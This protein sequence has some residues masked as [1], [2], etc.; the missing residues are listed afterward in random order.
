MALAAARAQVVLPLARAAAS[1]K[2]SRGWR[3]FGYACLD[4]LTRERYGRCGRWLVEVARLNGCFERLPGLAAAVCGEDGGHPLHVS[5]ALAIGDI[6]TPRSLA[7]WIAL[8]RGNTLARLRHEIRR[9]TAAGSTAPL[10]EEPTQALSQA[11]GSPRADAAAVQGDA[12]IQDDD[13]VVRMTVPP[14]VRAAFHETLGLFR[15]IKGSDRA[16]VTS[17]VEALIGEC[18]TDLPDGDEPGSW[19]R[20]V[21]AESLRATPSRAM[22]EEA[23]ARAAVDWKHLDACGSRSLHLAGSDLERL[24]R[25]RREA[26]EG[27]I[28]RLDAQLR[29]L[30]AL[31]GRF[32]LRLGEVLLHMGAQGAFRH[33]GFDG[34]GHYA[35]RRLG[36]SR[37]VAEDR[38][39]AARAIGPYA[40]L[41]QAYEEG[42]LP[43]EATRAVLH[44]IHGTTADEAAQRRWI[45]HARSA[46][47]KRLRDEVRVRALEAALGSAPGAS[48]GAAS[49]AA[50]GAAPG[51]TQGA[52][53]GHGGPG[54][55]PVSDSGSFSARS[56]ERAPLPMDDARWHA[57]LRREPGS[58]REMMARLGRVIMRQAGSRQA[59]LRLTLPA[60]LATSLGQLMGRARLALRSHVK[61]VPDGQPWPEPDAPASV[62]LTRIF[63]SQGWT[64]PAWVGLLWMLERCVDTWDRAEEAIRGHRR[65]ELFARSGY[66]CGAPGCTSRERLQDH[67]LQFR[68]AGGGNGL[69]NREVICLFHHQ[70]GIHGG[71]AAARGQAPLGITW[72]L[73]RADLGEWFRNERRLKS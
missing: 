14:A 13:V 60:E 59:S 61:Q 44:I 70:S 51:A 47:V 20:D 19:S 49:S 73:G 32:E 28:R 17:F 30:L 18:T 16:T 57:S 22:V 42:D 65:A 58:A 31:Q 34:L 46:T 3:Q 69:D 45:A 15:A 25:L 72:R 12:P 7:S 21:H 53:P 10:E 55:E 8:A 43:W 40:T 6:A 52:A 35:E 26:G 54:G 38:V 62:L 66:R 67:H 5:A 37:T 2:E 68:S 71:L 33:L 63:S 4:D 24:E 36:L 56:P 41:R 48:L 50:P 9:A 23:L 11:V 39:W 64:E 1:L 27:D 29:D